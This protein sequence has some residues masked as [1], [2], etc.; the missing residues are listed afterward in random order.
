MTEIALHNEQTNTAAAFDAEAA[1]YDAVF[2]RSAIGILQRNR[3]QQFVNRYVF[4]AKKNNTLELNCGTGEDAI[5][6]GANSNRVL[7]TDISGSMVEITKNK[8]AGLANVETMQL[9]FTGVRTAAVKGEF[10]F[11]FSNFGGLN[12]IGVNEL[13]ALAKQLYAITED[14]ATVALVVMS[15]NCYWENIYFLMKGFRNRRKARSMAVLNGI[16]FPVSYYSP[17]QLENIFAPYFEKQY[18]K[19]VGL[20]IPPSYLNHFFVRKQFLLKVLWVL[21]K[22]FGSWS[23]L[24][25]NAD[26]YLMILKKRTS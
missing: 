26:H 24:A 4:K 7:S 25:T 15:S 21:E 1:K 16:E 9:S 22:I 6:L 23:F 8:T 13:R 12:C 11:V 18:Q 3:V 20:F 17:K 5:W 19:P 10:D 2:S 14:N